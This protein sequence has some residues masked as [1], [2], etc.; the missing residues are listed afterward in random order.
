MQLNINFGK[1]YNVILSIGNKTITA[2]ILDLTT[3]H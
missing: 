2:D 1:G 3:F